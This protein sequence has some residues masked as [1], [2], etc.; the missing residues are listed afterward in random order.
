LEPAR[1]DDAWQLVFSGECIDGHDPQ[2]VRDAVVKA[3][4]FDEKRAARLFSGEPVVLRRRV[5]GATAQRHIERFAQMGAVLHAQPSK[6][7][8]PS[9]EPLPA[10]WPRLRLAGIGVLCVAVA[11]GFGL[12][13]VNALGPDAPAPGTV[14][15]AAVDAP[16]AVPSVPGATDASTGTVP[17][18]EPPA[19][20]ATD[21][22]IPKEMTAD[23]LREY[24][25]G[26]L[27][28]ANHKAFAISSR[29]AHAWIAGAA[30]ENDAR[31]RALASCMGAMQPGDDGC[32]VVDADGNWVN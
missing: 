23:A 2:A 4:K 28:A 6:P 13:L 9:P 21:E 31:E 7:L 25:L 24:R 22:E 19:R 1:P 17:A 14:P 27:V 20:P 11:A 10:R 8:A 29:G 32:R 26:Y 18:A 16:R 15:S 12:V 3:L 30:S 5:D